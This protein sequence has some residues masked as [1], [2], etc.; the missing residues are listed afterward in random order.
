MFLPGIIQSSAYHH[1][2][3][4]GDDMKKGLRIIDNPYEL[5]PLEELHEK[6]TTA[7]AWI[8]THFSSKNIYEA[9]AKLRQIERAIEKKEQK[10]TIQTIQECVFA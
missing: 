9:K 2:K 7:L 6:H 4:I 3:Q 1:W 5:Y 8:T 10:E